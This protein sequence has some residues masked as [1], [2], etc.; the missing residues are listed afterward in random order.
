MQPSFVFVYPSMLSLATK[1][2][3][4]TGKTWLQ[5]QKAYVLLVIV[6]ECAETLAVIW[7]WTPNV[8]LSLK[9]INKPLSGKLF[10]LDTFWHGEG[11]DLSWLGFT[12]ISRYGFFFLPGV[13]Q[14][15]CYPASHRISDLYTWDLAKYFFEPR[16]RPYCK[17]DVAVD[18]WPG[19]PIITH[20]PSSRS[21]GLIK[22][23]NILLEA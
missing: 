18:K 10:T 16:D 11:N 3:P 7:W 20:I 5:R 17:G 19:G 8:L 13:P 14:V 22:L 9:E 15:P 23:C 4:W 12:Y 2:Y 6:A 21:C 1:I